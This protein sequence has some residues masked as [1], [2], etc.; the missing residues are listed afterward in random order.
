MKNNDFWKYK[1]TYY[2][3]SFLSIGVVVF[4]S[5]LLYNSIISLFGI[6]FN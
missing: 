4:M 3:L 1:F 5:Y 2:L 6:I